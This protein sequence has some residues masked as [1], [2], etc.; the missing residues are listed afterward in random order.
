MTVHLFSAKAVLNNKKDGVGSLNI[1]F[2]LFKVRFYHDL[3]HKIHEKHFDIKSGQVKKT[4]PD[5]DEINMLIL[6]VKQNAKEL[7]M[8]YLQRGNRLSKEELKKHLGFQS[9]NGSFYEFFQQAINSRKRELDPETIR[10]HQ[11]SL[12]RMKLFRKELSFDELT[13]EFLEDFDNWLFDTFKNSETRRN[14]IRKDIKTYTLRALKSYQFTN[15]FEVIKVKAVRPRVVFLTREE[16]KRIIKYYEHPET[17]ESHKN[18]LQP[19]IFSCMT[20]LRISDIYRLNRKNIHGGIMVFQQYKGRKKNQNEKTIP[21]GELARQ[22]LEPTGPVFKRLISQQVLRRT[23]KVIATKLHI[24]KNLT[25]H[26]A[27]HTCGTLFYRATRDIYAVKELLGHRNIKETLIYAH[28]DDESLHQPIQLY[29]S[30]IINPN[31]ERKTGRSR[32]SPLV[33]NEEKTKTS[34]PSPPAPG[35][36]SECKPLPLSVRSSY[37]SSES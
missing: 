6:S 4:H 27:R 10:T 15:P 13:P 2:F 23:L 25:F 21:L 34:C 35:L 19:F 14:N 24:H 37:P 29:D 3:F 5:A 18:V 8:R 16:L 28:F 26:T 17:S 32:I 9:C 12:D 7:H 33:L 20:G 31:H 22:F 36:C 11:M 30:Y 1:Q